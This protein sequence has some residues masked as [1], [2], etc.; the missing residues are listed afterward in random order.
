MIPKRNTASD[1]LGTATMLAHS[2][3]LNIFGNIKNIIC[4]YTAITLV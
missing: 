3:N 4:D 2:A 1:T